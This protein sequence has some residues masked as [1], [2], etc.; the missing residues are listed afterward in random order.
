[1]KI[2]PYSVIL[3][4]LVNS[5]ISVTSKTIKNKAYEKTTND[6]CFRPSDSTEFNSQM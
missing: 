5:I 4:L 2:N 6:S 3:I 1:M